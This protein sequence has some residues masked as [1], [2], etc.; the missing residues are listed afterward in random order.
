VY[1]FSGLNSFQ[2]KLWA[3]KYLGAAL[4]VST[5]KNVNSSLASLSLKENT[6]Y[7]IILSKLKLNK[8]G[9]KWWRKVD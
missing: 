5:A 3:R 1:C 6:K 2:Q 8:K 4:R 9:K 7:E